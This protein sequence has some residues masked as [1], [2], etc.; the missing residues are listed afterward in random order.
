M[1]RFYTLLLTT[2]VLTTHALAPSLPTIRDIHVEGN[3]RIPTE[4]ITHRLTYRKGGAFDETLSTQAIE[5]VYS[6]NAFDQVMIEK[7]GVESTQVDLFITVT[8]KPALAEI[9]FTGNKKISTKKLEELIDA[10]NIRA[11]TQ[12]DADILANT[13][14]KEY[15]SSDYHEA[16]VTAT[17]TADPQNNQ[18]AFLIF[19][20]NEKV[21]SRIREIH[22]TGNTA[23]P[24]RT[25][26]TYIQNREVWLLCF[27]DGAGKFNEAALEID[28]ERIRAAYANKGY[29]A[30]RVTDTTVTRSSDQKNIDLTF[31]ISEGP[32][33]TIKEIDIAPDIEVPHRIVRK[34]LTLSPGDTYKLS[35][36]QRM[37][38]TIKQLYGEYGFIDAYVSPQVVPDTNTNTIAVTFHVEKGT[39]W[40]LNRLFITG[41][42]TTRD[43]VIRRQIALEEGTLIT[44]TALDFSKRNV[45][46]LSYFDRE[47]V[48]W[49][50]HRLDTEQLD[51]ELNVKEVPTRAFSMGLDF[52]ANQDDPNSGV[53]GTIGADLRNMFG[54]GWDMGFV[55]K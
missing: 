30:A 53:K 48:T 36:I 45:E 19:A 54:K 24:S 3:T 32:L 34:L 47:S 50:K 1:K 38:E 35:E 28:K 42:E 20:I 5:A 52:G 9:T 15:T 2:A 11:I 37:M 14:K 7:E 17:V 40:K 21:K 43:H 49:K 31:T 51:L 41:N 22:F 26:R 29:F 55:L 25:L 23:I 27:L 12:E 16:I 33:F 39:R 13:I 8:E 18:R 10:K 46:A 44:S 4:T 6:L